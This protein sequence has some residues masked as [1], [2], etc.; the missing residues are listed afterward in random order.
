LA[1]NGDDAIL[2]INDLGRVAWGRIGT[3]CGLSPSVGKVYFSK[4]F[5]NINSTTFN[6]HPYIK[7]SDTEVGWEGYTQF[8]KP[9]AKCP[10]GKVN[11]VRTFELVSYVNLGLLFGMKRSGGD[12]SIEDGLSSLS[13]GTRCTNLINDCPSFM[14]SVVMKKF[15][16]MNNDQLKKYTIPWFIPERFGGLGLPIVDVLP[17][18][19]E[20]RAA[21]KIFEHPKVFRLPRKPIDTPWKV[22]KYA[23]DR[24]PDSK[25]TCD[26]TQYVKCLKA[27][28]K[29]SHSFKSDEI[30][31]C[32]TDVENNVDNQMIDLDR[33]RGLACVEQLFRTC[34][35]SKVYSKED[36]TQPSNYLRAVSRCFKAALHDQNIK[37][38]E[39]FNPRNYPA[40]EKIT[41]IPLLFRINQLV[42]Y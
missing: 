11:R 15:V 5:L 41:D 6:F 40:D 35:I 36:V 13:I 17:Y 19:R 4:R 10:T 27:F 21:R 2:R 25:F 3:F 14:R 22:W 24:F 7:G 26:Y 8:V 42:N 23:C 18:D 29:S 39:P 33:L 12:Y 16:H 31:T 28:G 20:L 9:S 32:D 34:D 1:I 38:P 30:D 37:M